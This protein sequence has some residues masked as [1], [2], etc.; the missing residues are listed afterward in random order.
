MTK[1]SA[2]I[3]VKNE[4]DKIENTLKNISDLVDEIVI[5]DDYSDDN[6]CKIAEK[7]GA[8]I[9]KHK[10]DGFDEQKNIGIRNCSNEWIL[11]IDA[12][13]IL[14]PKTKSEIV[15]KINNGTNDA[16]I[17]QRDE[18]FL[19]KKIMQIGL[20]RLYKKSKSHYRNK[21]HEVLEVK[22]SIGKLKNHFAHEQYK[23]RDI[24]KQIEVINRYS[25]I[26]ADIKKGMS[27]LKIMINIFFQPLKHFF[28]H[29]LYKGLIFKGF[30]GLL[31]SIL[32]GYY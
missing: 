6:T 1:I 26:E 14:Y 27:K 29:L 7:Y 20:I 22:G 3:I 10:L 17:I 16:Y 24:K 23:Y 8:K 19:G 5:V 15:Q 4:G 30:A 25:S 31:Y 18:F 21:V 9:V 12:D 28:G 2:F 13:E 11:D 32:M